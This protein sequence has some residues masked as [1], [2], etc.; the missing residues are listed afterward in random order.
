MI[1]LNN[2]GN[3]TFFPKNWTDARIKEEVE[4]AVRYNKGLKNNLDPRQGYYGMSKDGSIEIR[5]YYDDV[6]KEIGSY[7]PQL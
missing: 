5:F 7:F 2:Q 6:T 4:H 3:S 1:K